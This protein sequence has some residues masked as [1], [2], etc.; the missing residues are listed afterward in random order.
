M[1][2]RETDHAS[3][4]GASPAPIRIT[5]EVPIWGVITALVA[6][7]AQAVAMYYGQQEQQRELTRQG[8][9][10]AEMAADIR[11]IATE[12]QRGNVEM[13]KLGYAVES[14]SQRVAV[15]ESKNN[16]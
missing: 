2:T 15:L 10:Q 6:L 14:L 16:K 7:G 9:R 8:V 4:D 5:R 12:A 3:L 11:S 13:A 1:G